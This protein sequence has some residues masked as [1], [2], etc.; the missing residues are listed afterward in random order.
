MR[1]WGFYCKKYPTTTQPMKIPIIP[2]IP[3]KLS[4]EGGL[5]PKIAKIAPI[6]NPNT[7]DCTADN[8]SD[9]LINSLMLCI[10]YF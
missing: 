10:S 1:D 3:A 2:R 4:G 9:L 7:P 6:D 8:N 5:N